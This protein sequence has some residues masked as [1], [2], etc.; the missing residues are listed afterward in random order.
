MFFQNYDDRKN[1][2]SLKTI[3]IQMVLDHVL[4]RFEYRSSIC[5]NKRK[6]LDKNGKKPNAQ[7]TVIKTT[8]VIN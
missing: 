2:T 4:T 8:M 7:T 6:R 5:N 1:T 3:K